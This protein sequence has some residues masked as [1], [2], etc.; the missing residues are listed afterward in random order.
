MMLCIIRD[1][2]LVCLSIQTA[3]RF[4][5]SLSQYFLLSAEIAIAKLSPR[6]KTKVTF[7]YSIV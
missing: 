1:V 5:G 3:L 4:V 2:Y 7:Y 6:E